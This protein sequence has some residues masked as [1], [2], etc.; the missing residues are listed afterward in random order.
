MLWRSAKLC[1]LYLDLLH[2]IITYS[3]YIQLLHTVITYGYYIWLLHTVITYG[4]YIRLLHTVITYG[5]LN[6]LWVTIEINEIR[7]L[8][9]E[10]P[11]D[12]GQTLSSF[13]TDT[14]AQSWPSIVHR[15]RDFQDGMGTHT[16]AGRASVGR[17]RVAGTPLRSPDTH[18]CG[19]DAGTC[20][21]RGG[22]CHMCDHMRHQLNG[23][24]CFYA[25][26]TCVMCDVCNVCAM[27]M[28]CVWCV[29][30][31]VCVHVCGMCVCMCVWWHCV[32][33]VCACVCVGGEEEGERPKLAIYCRARTISNKCPPHVLPCTSSPSG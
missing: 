14:S 13:H 6:N 32:R 16:G 30:V 27:C 31:H 18:P 23:M 8:T 11:S 17:C 9:P 12:N 24:V 33:G 28:W 5:Y 20:A 1:K 22:A 26:V 4:Y 21:D 10:R 25:S 19:R 2:T 3:Y 29:C 15:D 7:P